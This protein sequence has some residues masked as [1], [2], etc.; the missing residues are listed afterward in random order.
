MDLWFLFFLSFFFYVVVKC[1][2]RKE[3]ASPSLDGTVTRF[4]RA[5]RALISLLRTVVFH[6]S[7]VYRTRRNIPSVHRL[8]LRVGTL[9]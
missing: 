9:R 4:Q 3:L 8:S 1:C 6:S 2:I 5:L 7:T